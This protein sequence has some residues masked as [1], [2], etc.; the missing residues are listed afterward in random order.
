[1]SICFSFIMMTSLWHC[2]QILW[3]GLA[4]ESIP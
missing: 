4:V 1:M 2:K 3:G